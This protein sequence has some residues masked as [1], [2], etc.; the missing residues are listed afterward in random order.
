MT[1]ATTQR[2]AGG[3]VRRPGA[4][5]KP[6]RRE[7]TP[8]RMTRAMLKRLNDNGGPPVELSPGLDMGVRR[9]GPRTARLPKRPAQDEDITGNVEQTVQK[10]RKGPQPEAKESKSEGPEPLRSKSA[11]SEHKDLEI[12][13]PKPAEQQI[14][15]SIPAEPHSITV[16]TTISETIPPQPTTPQPSDLETGISKADIAAASRLA[17]AAIAAGLTRKTPEL[18]TP[19]TEDRPSLVRFTKSDLEDILSE[20]VVEDGIRQ[21]M[22]PH[23]LARTEFLTWWE[24]PAVDMDHI[25]EQVR[26]LAVR[27]SKDLKAR[28]PDDSFIPTPILESWRADLVITGEP[29]QDTGDSV[30]ENEAVQSTEDKDTDHDMPEELE[31]NINE[32]GMEE[33]EGRKEGKDQGSDW[34]DELEGGDD[35]PGAA[36]ALADALTTAM[37]EMADWKETFDKEIAA[38][39]EFRRSRAWAT[40]VSEYQQ[41]ATA[42]EEAA[43]DLGTHK[44][45]LTTSVGEKAAKVLLSDLLH[46]RHKL[47]MD[48]AAFWDE[49]DEDEAEISLENTRNSGKTEGQ[50]GDDDT[51]Q[52]EKQETGAVP[53]TKLQSGPVAKY[54]GRFLTGSDSEGKTASEPEDG[55]IQTALVRTPKEDTPMIDIEDRHDLI[56]DDGHISKLEPRPAAP[57]PEEENNDSDPKSRLAGPEHKANEE[58]TEGSLLPGQHDESAWTITEPTVKKNG[59]IPEIHIW[60]D[61]EQPAHET[62][63]DLL[64]VGGEGLF[65]PSPVAKLQRQDHEGGRAEVEEETSS[66]EPR[67]CVPQESGGQSPSRHSPSRRLPGREQPKSKVTNPSAAASAEGQSNPFRDAR[68]NM[69]AQLYRSATIEEAIDEDD[70]TIDQAP[71]SSDKTGLLTPETNSAASSPRSASPERITCKVQNADDSSSIAS[72]ISS[73]PEDLGSPGSGRSETAEEVGEGDVGDLAPETHDVFAVP[74]DTRLPQDMNSS[75]LTVSTEGTEE[76]GSRM[77]ET[78]EDISPSSHIKRLL[79]EASIPRD[80]GASITSEPS[81]SVGVTDGK[82]EETVERARTPKPQQGTSLP[83]S[84]I[85]SGSNMGLEIQVEQAIDEGPAAPNA[86]ALTQRGSIGGDI[87]SPPALSIE[88]G[89]MG[90]PQV[91][92]IKPQWEDMGSLFSPEEPTY[93]YSANEAEED[94]DDDGADSIDDKETDDVDP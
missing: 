5:A 36:E 81:Q 44:F 26:R 61:T 47:K 7:I 9:R 86:A 40:I 85:P 15:E 66:P 49:F 25:K 89:M 27:W 87:D 19:V 29:R 91:W 79:E 4:K 92:Y 69:A 24:R 21:R 75:V 83:A 71:T 2:R 82:L 18:A 10:K 74:E 6:Q 38:Q 78:V 58:P 32:G 42:L 3:V 35:K 90:V 93:V 84:G 55:D 77:E 52:G 94:D 45:G 30:V 20:A 76:V 73:L 23:W 37:R 43:R 64:R 31:E 63:L 59:R 68:I 17:Q 65:H 34:I 16:Q 62:P 80:I 72:N 46:F 1:S 33:E 60:R 67:P 11:V 14:K 51:P 8:P 12:I 53:Q 39:P 50:L 88:E 54:E 41:Q 70:H 57:L 56:T 28:S 13:G 22:E 48:R